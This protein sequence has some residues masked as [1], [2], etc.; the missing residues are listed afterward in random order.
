MNK[1]KLLKKMHHASRGNLFSIEVQKATKEDERQ[2]DQFVSELEREG[3]IKLREVVQR[4]YS[5]YL[6]GIV[7]Y[8]SE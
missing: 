8:A 1:D 4:E 6:H 2:I 7:K 5:V 3:K